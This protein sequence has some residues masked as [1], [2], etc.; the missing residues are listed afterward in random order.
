MEELIQN[1]ELL[2]CEGKLFELNSVL[3]EGK[4]V[5]IFIYSK[6]QKFRCNRSQCPLKE[7]L[8]RI[9]D[10]DVTVLSI[11]EDS[12]EQNMEFKRNFEIP[13]KIL[14]D[15][16]L[17]EIKGFGAYKK[18]DINGI[19]R[20]EVIDT[21]I[22]VNEKGYILKKWTNQELEKLSDEVVN[23]VRELKKI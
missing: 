6:N 14:S 7:N 8:K 11:N 21:G 12:F 23:M 22:L 10:E 1:F 9:M 18:V 2:D 16:T 13:F 4:I 5:F 17:K 3:N 19:E 20:E 15:P